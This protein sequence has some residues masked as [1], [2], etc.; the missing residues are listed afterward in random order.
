[1]KL[2]D[3]LWEAHGLVAAYDPET[4]TAYL[5]GLG[6]TTAWVT[7]TPIPAGDDHPLAEVT[8]RREALAV[9]KELLRV[10]T[11]KELLVLHWDDTHAGAGVVRPD[12]ITGD[13]G[14]VIHPGTLSDQIKS[15]LPLA[16]AHL[17]TGLEIA[18]QPV[19]ATLAQA[20]DYWRRSGTTPHV[21]AYEAVHRRLPENAELADGS[22]LTPMTDDFT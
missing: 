17:C 2:E 13:I 20:I 12:E 10:C 21:P 7:V 16:L 6:K 11:L 15:E 1:M 18:F 4:R 19:P 8:S 14:K 22:P 3:A 9:C 5:C